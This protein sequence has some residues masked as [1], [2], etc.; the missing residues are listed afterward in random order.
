M[1]NKHEN[2]NIIK[3]NMGEDT[4]LPNMIIGEQERDPMVMRKNKIKQ[5]KLTTLWKTQITRQT[6]EQARRARILKGE[7][8]RA[9]LLAKI[10]PWRWL[11]L[12]AEKVISEVVAGVIEISGLRKEENQ[13]L[14]DKSILELCKINN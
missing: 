1:E 13:K 12:E 14:K 11:E 8:K 6:E 4:Q 10:Q 3:D 7:G 9:E 5:P 2:K